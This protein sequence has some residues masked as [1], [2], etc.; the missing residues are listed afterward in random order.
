M[1]EHILIVEDDISLANGLCRA[2]ESEEVQTESCGT[3]KEAANGW[4]PGSRESC[5]CFYWM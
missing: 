5:R 2:L 1:V 3:L 4:R